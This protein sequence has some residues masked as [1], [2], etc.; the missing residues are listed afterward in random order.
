MKLLLDEMWSP[1]IALQLRHRGHDVSAVVEREELRGQPDVAILAT[2][3]AEGRAV[4]T[5]NARDFRPL[6][7]L[8]IQIGGYHAGL[9]L[10]DDNR[11]SRHDSR[12]LGRLVSAL[13]AL[14]TSNTDVTNLEIWL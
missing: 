8:T 2:A 10:T 5:D 4:V 1:E 9:I 3:R 13:D 14:L 11:F 6:G 12:T 7:A